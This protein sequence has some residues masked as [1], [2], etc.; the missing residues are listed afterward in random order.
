MS[1]YGDFI[2][3]REDINI[4][5]TSKGFI[6][7]TVNAN[8]CCIHNIYVDPQYRDQGEGHI[9]FNH[10]IE[11]ATQN[12]LGDLY[13]TI[14][15]SPAGSHKSLCILLKQGFTLHSCVDNLIYMKFILGGSHG[16]TS[17]SF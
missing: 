15:P 7:Y 11:V 14:S 5:E 2:K 16:I 4:F 13:A 3:E 17:G 9:L 6:T 8:G 12:G 1:L 10:V